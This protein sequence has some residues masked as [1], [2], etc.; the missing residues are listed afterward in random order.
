MNLSSEPS[1]FSRLRTLLLVWLGVI[2]AFRLL[3]LIPP[4]QSLFLDILRSLSVVVL[5]Y[6]P[7]IISYIKRRPLPYWQL[8]LKVA[9]EDL[10]YFALLSLIIFPIMILGNHFYQSLLFDLSYHHPTWDIWVEKIFPKAVEN[11]ILVAFA[12]E[13]FF[14]GY[15]QA[16]MKKVLPNKGKIFGADFGWFAV[17]TSLLFAISHSLAFQIAWWHIFIFFP[18][19]IFAWLR[20][21][22]GTIWGAVLFHGVSNIFS[23]WVALTYYQ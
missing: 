21:K 18:A 5:I 3:N 19:L 10:K 15:M 13:F 12:E 6:P 4:N 2:V 11:I 23:Y 8:N 17:L 16:E 7:V 14:R 22:T 1:K 20:E 9:K